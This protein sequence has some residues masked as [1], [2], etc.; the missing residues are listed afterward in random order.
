MFFGHA[1]GANNGIATYVE[2]YLDY[3]Y[4]IKADISLGFA[5]TGIGSD[6]NTY[7]DKRTGKPMTHDEVLSR[8][9]CERD[10]NNQL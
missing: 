4:D 6:P 5:G 9:W 8:I 7:T 10:Y 1:P 2:W 3:Y